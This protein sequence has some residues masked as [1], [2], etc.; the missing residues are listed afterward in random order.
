MKKTCASPLLRLGMQKADY[1][2]HTLTS[3][4]IEA[5]V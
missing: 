1:L 5:S 3:L 2:S 4:R